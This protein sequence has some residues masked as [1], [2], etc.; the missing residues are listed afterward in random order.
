[1]P[2][3]NAVIRVVPSMSW[4]STSM[5]SGRGTIPRTAKKLRHPSYCSSVSADSSQIRGLSS[6]S[7]SPSAVRTTAAARP[8]LI[9]GA[10]RPMPLAKLC[11]C[12]TR[13]RTL[14]S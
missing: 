13:S 9:C 1:M 3:S 6:V 2:F 11:T 5:A 8:M 12:P 10:A 7:V 14:T 4:C